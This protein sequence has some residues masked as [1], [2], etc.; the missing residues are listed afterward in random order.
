MSDQEQVLRDTQENVDALAKMGLVPPEKKPVV[1]TARKA[2]IFKRVWAEI[3]TRPPALLDAGGM[4]ARLSGMRFGL[5]CLMVQGGYKMRKGID[6][7]DDEIRTRS[8]ATVTLI[9]NVFIM[10]QAAE[11]VIVRHSLT[12]EYQSV[13]SDLQKAVGQ[14]V[15]QPTGVELEK[16][17]G[18]ARLRWR[19]GQMMARQTFK[20]LA[21]TVQVPWLKKVFTVI[22]RSLPKGGDFVADAD[23]SPSSHS[24]EDITEIQTIMYDHVKGARVKDGQSFQTIDEFKAK[25]R[26]GFWNPMSG[27]GSQDDPGMYNFAYIPVSMS[28]QEATAYYA[29]GGIPAVVTDKKAKGCLLNGYTFEGDRV[30]AGRDR[31]AARLRR[32]GRVRARGCRQPSRWA[33]IRRGGMLPQL[34]AGSRRVAGREEHRR[35]H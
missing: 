30:D 10:L 24:L 5:R 29:S 28:P 23:C 31:P 26:D 27:V 6:L 35:P 19:K 12:D 18:G 1:N 11:D 13:C 20:T 25:V 14:F 7:R 33:D 32:E 34:Q 16:L 8:D 21:E 3:R 15:P 9:H 17:E 4:E 22:N 2:N